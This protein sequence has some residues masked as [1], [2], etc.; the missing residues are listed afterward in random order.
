MVGVEK[1]SIYNATIFNFYLSTVI[2]NMSVLFVNS[3]M[4]GVV[5]E[6]VVADSIYN[7]VALQV[8]EFKSVKITNS[9]ISR[10]FK[11]SFITGSEFLI[12]N[13]TLQAPME[14]IGVYNVKFSNCVMNQMNTTRPTKETMF[15]VV[16]SENFQVE[17]STFSGNVVNTIFSAFKIT[18]IRLSNCNHYVTR[19]LF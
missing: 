9:I 16:G 1:L 5:L 10:L 12:G 19:D 15:D 7:V 6:M 18:S 2:V 11:M 13:C 8:T 4:M 17:N 3:I 14:I